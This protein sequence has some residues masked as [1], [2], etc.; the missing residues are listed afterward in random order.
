MASTV[1]RMRARTS[2]GSSG[3]RSMTSARPS[4]PSRST[5]AASSGPTS[6]GWAR[7]VAT[8]VTGSSRSRRTS[9]DSTVSVSASAAWRSSMASTTGAGGRTSPAAAV[10]ARRRGGP[11]AMASP[12]ASRVEPGLGLVGPR[13]G[14]ALVVQ[15]RAGAGRG[16][17]RRTGRSRSRSSSRPSRTVWP[18]SSA[19]ARTSSRKRDFPMPASPRTT[20]VGGLAGAGALEGVDHPLELGVTADEGA[21]HRGCGR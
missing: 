5:V 21:G 19:W 4:R 1:A 10:R 14:V 20:R 8:N 17:R 7:I 11:A 2:S 13:V 18:S 6:G 12:P 9:W 16:R 3:S 15:H